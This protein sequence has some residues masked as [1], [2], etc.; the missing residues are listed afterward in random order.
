MAAA[1]LVA[2]SGRVGEL[3]VAKSGPKSAWQLLSDLRVIAWHLQ[4]A[5]L[6]EGLPATELAALGGAVSEA[7]EELQ[8][9]I[10][11][12]RPTH[13]VGIRMPPLMRAKLA[14]LQR[15]LR[16]R[17]PGLSKAAV[18]MDKS[19]VTLIVTKV[20]PGQADLA[21]DALAAAA[22]AWREGEGQEVCTF[23]L[24]G[25]GVF[26]RNGVFFVEMGPLASLRALRNHVAREFSKRGLLALDDKDIEK[27]TNGD[28]LRQKN[29]KPKPKASGQSHHRR[30]DDDSGDSWSSELSNDEE[31]AINGGCEAAAADEDASL[32][33]TPAERLLSYGSVPHHGKGDDFHP[34][35]TLFK[36]S[37]AGRGKGE[38]KQSAAAKK[39][40]AQ[41]AKALDKKFAAQ[42]CF[43]EASLVTA[44]L[45]DM[46]NTQQDGYY[47][48]QAEAVLAEVAGQ[49]APSAHPAEATTAT[50]TAQ[51]AAA[52][53]PATSGATAAF[54]PEV[55]E[56]VMIEW[57]DTWHQG[58]VERRRKGKY[59]VIYDEDGTF[60]TV[61]LE[62]LRRRTDATEFNANVDDGEDV[63]ILGEPFL[64][65]LNM[66][67]ES[68]RGEPEGKCKGVP[69]EAEKV[70][71]DD[72]EA[73][74]EHE[75]N[76]PTRCGRR[77][78]K[79]RRKKRDNVGS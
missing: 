36:A 72:A 52:R 13:F 15:R 48:V 22:A 61:S 32:T 49:P 75:Q 74:K 78:G 79:W 40:I 3:L 34:H 25:I 26:T 45:V 19:H 77:G 6:A 70:Q 7:A 73:D 38:R 68:L 2:P 21:R 11:R 66:F 24:R 60:E 42:F 51:V 14:A 50:S 4:N 43:G 18:T 28:D 55:G 53:R 23:F 54:D 69:E 46:R 33:E 63:T 8:R 76:A 47:E 30:H 12:P 58:V 56:E 20:D 35:V 71:E 29:T 62:R 59:K 44:E 27:D 39:A 5:A 67:M 65:T 64:E 16:Q 17:D 37:Q 10:G 41:V 57:S 1:V 9:S 31:D